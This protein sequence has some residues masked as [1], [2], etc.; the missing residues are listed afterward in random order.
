MHNYVKLVCTI[1]R[2]SPRNNHIDQLIDPTYNQDDHLPLHLLNP[3]PAPTYET[4]APLT[5]RDG[6][7]LERTEIEDHGY[8]V[9]NRGTPENKETIHNESNAHRSNSKLGPHEDPI[10]KTE[11]EINP[12]YNCL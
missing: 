3:I 5:V 10:T 9:L 11:V 8:D 6:T 1:V 12:A 4:I 2:K 7:K